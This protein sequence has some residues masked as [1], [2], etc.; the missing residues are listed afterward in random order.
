MQDPER[1]LLYTSAVLSGPICGMLGVGWGPVMTRAGIVATERN[2]RAFL[3]S[4][5][6]YLALW[7]AMMDLSR[8]QDVSKLLGL[9]MASGPAIPV[10]FALS[11]A[12]DFETGISRMSKFKSLFGPMRF[13]VSQT[14]SEFSVR[15]AP[16]R[17]DMSLPGSFSSPQVIYL[18]AQANALARQAIRPLQ[19]FLPL[20]QGERERLTDVF[21]QVPDEGDA[22]LTYTRAD[23]R[24]PFISDNPELWVATEAD[25]HA[26]SRIQSKG[27]PLSERVRA[28]ILEAFSVT[29]PTIAHV[30]GR[31][32]LSRSTLM[33]RLANEGGNFPVSAGRNKERA[34]NSLSGQERPEQPTDRVSRRLSGSE[35][36][37][38]RLPK[39]DRNEPPGLEGGSLLDAGGNRDRDVLSAYPQT[40]W[41][42]D[43]GEC[44]QCRLQ[45]QYSVAALK[46]S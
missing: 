14:S 25:L 33:R 5:E 26:Q 46:V 39:V 45:P 43:G 20:P 36:V 41:L 44:R 22:T 42:S 21:G 19:V 1:S 6:E 24:I 15:V 18:H 34:G 2:D 7:A 30:C 3:V 4:A 35:R 10:L 8:Q 11:T 23:A 29:D 40:F 28:T 9:R 32:R 17:P 13:V 27:L 16:D 38:A 37:S 31:L 12:P